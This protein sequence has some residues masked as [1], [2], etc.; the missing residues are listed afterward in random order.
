MF[1]KRG[2]AVSKRDLDGPASPKPHCHRFRASRTD[3]GKDETSAQTVTASAG[4]S[5]S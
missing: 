2:A 5:R 3:G 1:Q 4:S